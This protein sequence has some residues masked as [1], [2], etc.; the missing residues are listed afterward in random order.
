MLVG[1]EGEYEGFNHHFKVCAIVFDSNV[2][3]W[4]GI[5]VL[6]LQVT[7]SLFDALSNNSEVDHPLCE[8]CTDSILELMDHQLRLTEDEQKDY[9]IFLERYII[10]ILL[11]L[12]T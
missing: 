7:A 6:F 5:Y 1:G 9:S 4:Y 10:Y 11:S 8:E 3:F 12:T 2:R